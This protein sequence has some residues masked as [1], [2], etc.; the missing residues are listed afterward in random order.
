ME[1]KLDQ[2][3]I[4]DLCGDTS[5]KRGRSFCNS[6][7]IEI[8]LEAATRME[9]IVS[10]TKTGDFLVQIEKGSVHSNGFQSSC[11][12]P[13]LASISKQCQH[14]AAVLLYVLDRQQNT[15]KK[16]NE[17]EFKND[18]TEICPITNLRRG[19]GRS[20]KCCLIVHKLNIVAEYTIFTL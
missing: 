12:C 17:Q 15:S 20:S 8:Q 2:Q 1:L 18:F 5:V 6:K 14:V 19:V 13:S 3:L 10:N 7:S 9:C 16:L 11:S 4:F